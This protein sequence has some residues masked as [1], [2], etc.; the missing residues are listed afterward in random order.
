MKARDRLENIKQT[1]VIR[2]DTELDLLEKFLEIVH[3]YDP[4][5]LIGNDC[6]F[7][8]DVLVSK[9]LSL[10][11]K[12]WSRLGKIKRL[13]QPY[14]KVFV[15]FLF[16]ILLAFFYVFDFTLFALQ[17]KINLGQFFA[18]R[19]ICDITT[20]AKELNLKV[21]SYDLPALCVAVN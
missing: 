1:K 17:G 19:P 14:F 6:G 2:C 9:I 5:I 8:F 7:K 18:G 4:D 13:I 11:V 20:S 16:L 21:K 12:N 10:K 3:T 15:Y